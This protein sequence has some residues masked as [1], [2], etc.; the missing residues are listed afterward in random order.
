[1]WNIAVFTACIHPN[2]FTEEQKKIREKQYED[3]LKF[4]IHNS[5]FDSIVFVDNSN[6]NLNYLKDMKKTNGFYTINSKLIEY[7]TYNWN[8]YTEKYNYWY[9]EAE[10][11]DYAIDNSQL[12]DK[13]DDNKSF[14]KVT[15]RHIIKKINSLIWMPQDERFFR[16]VYGFS[17]ISAVFKI[18]KKNYKDLLYKKV[19]DFYIKNQKQNSINLEQVY[20][21]LLREKFLYQIDKTKWRRIFF[22]YLNDW[23][24]R[25]W[26]PIKSQLINKILY[27]WCYLLK[28][29]QFGIFSKIL[30]ELFFKKWYQKKFWKNA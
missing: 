16:W 24:I 20:Y 29:N 6:S 28:L 25:F 21:I 23:S 27:T 15:G 11:I 22:H 4:Y 18:K 13:L 12:L 14:F 9:S 17:C 2:G 26:T 10:I 7:I 19:E 5:D 30:D 3:S 1:M 8:K